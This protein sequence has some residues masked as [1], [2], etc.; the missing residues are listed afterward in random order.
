[1]RLAGVLLHAGIGGDASVKQGKV[2]VDQVQFARRACARMCR[3]K[4]PL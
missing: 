4:S 3:A 2:E 1:V